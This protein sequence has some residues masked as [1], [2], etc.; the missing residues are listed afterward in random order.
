MSLRK[1]P[2]TAL[3]HYRA[4]V[5]YA[6][7]MVAP[8]QIAPDS[9]GRLSIS[10]A[11]G[12]GHSDIK[13]GGCS[14]R[15]V[16][17]RIRQAQAD[18]RATERLRLS[19]FLGSASTRTFPDEIPSGRSGRSVRAIDGSFGGV[20]VA[21]EW[22]ALGVGAGV[23][24]RNDVRISRGGTSGPAARIAPQIYLRLGSAEGWHGRIHSGAPVIAGQ[25]PSDFIG[26][27]G[28]RLGRE[29]KLG[30]FVGY[31]TDPMTSLTGGGLVVSTMIPIAH[32]LDLSAS[33]YLSNRSDSEALVGSIGARINLV[34]R[35]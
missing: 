23:T 30:G 19:A 28:Y 9:T 11:F 31:A 16:E 35:E 6:L 18:F 22:D 15:V 27:I 12:S 20:L 17:T 3:F 24:S 4:A 26:G 32:W 13:S 10:L 5:L 29:K 1:Q 25:P 34:R 2:G 8:L 33:T 7:W 21:H 14:Y